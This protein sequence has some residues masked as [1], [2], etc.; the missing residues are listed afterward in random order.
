MF[1]IRA[2]LGEGIHLASQPPRM[3]AHGEIIAFDAIGIN[4]GA[5]GGSFQEALELLFRSINQARGHVHDPTALALFDN[6]RVAQLRRWTFARKGQSPTWALP[7]R[8]IGLAV[9]L[10]ECLRIMRKIIA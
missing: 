6:H 5:D 7:W 1:E 9:N 2:L 10:K 4:C 8:R 3:L